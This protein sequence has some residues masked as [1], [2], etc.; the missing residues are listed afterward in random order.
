[1]FDLM[2]GSLII[3]VVLAFFAFSKLGA[4][5]FLI[6]KKELPRLTTLQGQMAFPEVDHATVDEQHPNRSE[7]HA[8]A[9]K[10]GIPE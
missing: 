2:L 9:S 6:G 8:G 10:S 5:D 3:G 4:L 7:S 1:M